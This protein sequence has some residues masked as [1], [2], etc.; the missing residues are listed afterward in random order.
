[1]SRVARQQTECD[2]QENTSATHCSVHDDRF[3]HPLALEARTSG[4]VGHLLYAHQS[5]IIAHCGAYALLLDGTVACWGRNYN[6][7]TDVV[8]F[9]IDKATPTVIA[10]ISGVVSIAAG[11]YNTCVLHKDATLACWS[12]NYFGQ[13]GDGTTA[14]STMPVSLGVPALSGVAEIAAGSWHSCARLNDKTVKCWGDNS[15][16]QLG[17]GTTLSSSVP[18]TVLVL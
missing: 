4:F 2:K 14:D 13:L 8:D 16:G 11:L 10:G 6:Y 5:L 15:A 17:N 3:Y 12:N 18:V 1:M 9:L 7:A